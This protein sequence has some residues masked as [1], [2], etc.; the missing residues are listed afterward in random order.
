[1]LMQIVLQDVKTSL[2]YKAPGVWTRDVSEAMDFSSSQRALKF[3]KQHGLMG[4][5]VLVAFVEPAYVETVAL[6]MP[7]GMAHMV[8]SAAAA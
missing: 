2:Y 4:V 3:V 1:V 6:Q 5:Q 8:G 7:A